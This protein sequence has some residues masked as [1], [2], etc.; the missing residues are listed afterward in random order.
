[1]VVERIRQLWE[2]NL[3]VAT[4]RSTLEDEGWE[5]GDNE[6]QRLRKGNGFIRRGTFGAYDTAPKGKK[7]KRGMPIRDT[8]WS[9]LAISRSGQH[10]LWLLD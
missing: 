1:M 7:R 5:L 8:C 9:L 6:F 4:I 2:Q 10:H 3:P